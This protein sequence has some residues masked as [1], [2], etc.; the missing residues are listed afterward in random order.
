MLD[1]SNFKALQPKLELSTYA[2]LYRFF[3]RVLNAFYKK[4]DPKSESFAFGC[5]ANYPLS[6]GNGEKE[7][8]KQVDPEFFL[9]GLHFELQFQFSGKLLIYGFTMDDHDDYSLIKLEAIYSYLERNGFS[10]EEN[11]EDGYRFVKML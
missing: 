10:K 2:Y 9:D 1:F 5:H 3:E 8:S 7:F 6:F 4:L 11:K